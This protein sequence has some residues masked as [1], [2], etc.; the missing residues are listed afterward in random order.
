ME[1]S[2][3]LHALVALPSGIKAADRRMDVFTPGM[4][5]VEKRDISNL[6]R[7]LNGFPDRPSKAL[8]PE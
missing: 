3:Q 8:S 4:K 1:I 5:A 6:V 7:E 2:E